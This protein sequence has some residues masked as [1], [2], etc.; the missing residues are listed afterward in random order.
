MKQKHRLDFPVLSDAGNAFASELG[1]TH[2]LP[3]ELRT[4]YEAFGTK[5]PAFNGDDSWTLPIPARV[6]IDT[7]G[8]IRAI[9]AD[10][11]YTRRPEPDATLE[12]LRALD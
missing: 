10:P 3:A 7:T 12:I 11:D 4:I 9:H 2:A 6:V 5:L 8:T 1:L